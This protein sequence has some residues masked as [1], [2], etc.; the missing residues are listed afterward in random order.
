[1]IKSAEISPCGLYRYSLTRKWEA[2]KGTV[3]FIMLNPSTADAQEDDPTIRRCIGF[4]KAW[5]YGGIVV[6]NLFAYRA[7]NPKELK[8]VDKP[9]GEHNHLYQLE[10]AVIS[11]EL[12]VCAWGAHGLQ[13]G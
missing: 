1:M 10:A 3:N 12:T 9:F 7:T 2:W 6:T 5:G 8:K 13:E 11:S 4:A